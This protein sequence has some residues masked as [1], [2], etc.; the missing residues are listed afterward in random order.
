M[1]K[2]YHNNRGVSSIE[3]AILAVG[4]IAAVS[5]AMRAFGGLLTQAFMTIGTQLTA[6]M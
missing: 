6:A 4:I 2:I 5:A 1:S 3:Y